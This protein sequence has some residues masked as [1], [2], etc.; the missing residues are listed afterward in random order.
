MLR[1]IRKTLPSGQPTVAGVAKVL[2]TRR[3]T[4]NRRL[5]N[6]QT[7]FSELLGRVRV[8]LGTHYLRSSSLSIAE[9]SHALGF[10]EVAAFH[11]A[12]KRWT[13]E[14]PGDFRERERRSRGNGPG[15]D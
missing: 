1:V 11:R 15:D 13:S 8:D 5:A 2:G 9:I 12:F 10:S 3:A 4:L 7:T 14:N 6:E